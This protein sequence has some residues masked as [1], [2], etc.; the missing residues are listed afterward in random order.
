VGS[1]A[2]VPLVHDGVVHGVL[3]VY[4]V[5]PDAFGPGERAVFAELGEIVGY[6]ID[7]TER[8]DARE[9]ATELAFVSGTLASELREAAAGVDAA[10]DDGIDVRIDVDTVVPLPDGTQ[11]QYWDVVGLPAAAAVTALASS[12]TV[13][14]A[15]LVSTVDGVHRVELHCTRESLHAALGPFDGRLASI[16]VADGELRAR[17]LFE[18]E[19]DVDAVTDAV[20]AVYP[21]L[22]L[23]SRRTVLTETY[24]RR[25]VE[26]SLTERQATV[27]RVAHAGGYFEQPRASTGPELAAQLDITRQTFHHHLR[28]AEAAVFD[29]LLDPGGETVAREGL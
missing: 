7:V 24:L 23:A 25:V 11:F 19:I 8:T 4:A 20:R 13:T 6:A 10:D 28:R 27:L 26:E 14:D 5:R 18:A 29:A 17:T 21:S 1:Y 12:S 3:G 16:V 9:P 2:A 22:E 15:R